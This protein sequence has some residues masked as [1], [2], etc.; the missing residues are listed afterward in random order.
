MNREEFKK[1]AKE[2]KGHNEDYIVKEKVGKGKEFIPTGEI[3]ENGVNREWG[4]YIFSDE[5][6]EA[7]FE[8]K[9]VKAVTGNDKIVIGRLE[10]GTYKG[11]EYWGF[12]IGIPDKTA[13]HKWTPEERAAL[14]DGEL[15]YRTDFYSPKKC[16][17]FEATAFWDEVEREIVLSFDKFDEEDE[18]EADF[19]DENE[20]KIDDKE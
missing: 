19:L 12:Q 17:T 3:I 5:E 18:G 7:L 20:D 10:K 8:G 15:I 1:R 9:E 13:G 4:G 11:N 14:Y 16:E 6:I 2:N